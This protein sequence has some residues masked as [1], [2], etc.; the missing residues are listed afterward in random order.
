MKKELKSINLVILILL[1][2]DVLF[3]MVKFAKKYSNM[4]RIAS[5]SVKIKVLFEN[6]P[7]EIKV[8]ISSED[9]QKL[10]ERVLAEILGIDNIKKYP[11]R[12]DDSNTT[13][14]FNLDISVSKKLLKYTSLKLYSPIAFETSK[15]RLDGKLIKIEGCENYQ[16]RK[17]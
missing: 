2:I 4:D 14:N 13:Y 16:A 9:K 12:N 7:E 1:I 11:Y 10:G 5:E 6:I 17:F 8:M 15:Y 3:F